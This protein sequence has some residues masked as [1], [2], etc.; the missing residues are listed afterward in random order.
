MVFFK[1]RQIRK[2]AI[3]VL[4]QSRHLRNTRDDLMRANDLEKLSGAETELEKKLNDRNWSGVETATGTLYDLVTR[5]S[6][7]Y[8]YPVARENVEVLFVAVAVAMAFRTY[9]I[10]P[11]KIPTG[12]MEPT[13][14]GIHAVSVT[15]PGITD[16]WPLKMAK[17]LVTG[18]WYTEIRVK[19]TG[20]LYPRIDENPDDRSVVYCYVGDVRYMIPRD[21]AP[22]LSSR[23]GQ[24]LNKGE[25]VCS[26]TVRA[27]DHVFVDKVSWNFR[28]PRRGEVIV[29]RTDN[30]GGLMENT[31]YI[32]RLVGLPKE[33]ISIDP[34][35]L[36]V[37]GMRI[38]GPSG[39]DRVESM[40]E[41]GYRWY[42]L[43]DRHPWAG[44]DRVGRMPILTAKSESI[45]LGPCEYLGFGDNT[46]NSQ[47]SRYWGAIPQ[48][49]LVG[50]ACLIYW[51]F[52][53]KNHETTKGWGKI[54]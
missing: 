22:L 37:D 24:Y 43:A 23:F 4:R 54:K 20:Q 30:I 5:F 10:Q 41:P 14:Y 13:L 2:S 1:N 31:H 40:K 38:T 52:A 15:E 21:A 49:N 36:V 12:S 39:I 11:F 35:Y 6:P 17:W 29:F 16:K 8:K 42:Q 32:K 34:P 46:G 45:P 18:E 3:H 48:E 7:T 25:L 50:P 53:P 47:D 27:G 51:P 26:M 44:P 19:M 33:A 9:F 28:R